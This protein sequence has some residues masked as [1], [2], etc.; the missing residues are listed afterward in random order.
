MT[1]KRKR[2]SAEFS[3]EL[4]FESGQCIEL[5]ISRRGCSFLP[6]G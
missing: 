2:Y 6:S 1:G 5:L 3:V 4:L